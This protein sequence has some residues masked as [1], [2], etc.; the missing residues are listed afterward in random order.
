MCAEVHDLC[1]CCVF[2]N[3]VRIGNAHCPHLVLRVSCEYEDKSDQFLCVLCWS[4]ESE[5]SGTPK[6]CCLHLT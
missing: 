3:I 5:A 2:V 1:V 4:F 6:L